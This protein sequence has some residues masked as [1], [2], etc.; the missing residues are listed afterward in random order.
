MRV[1]NFC[2]PDRANW[3]K[4]SIYGFCLFCDNP[5]S[6]LKLNFQADC[7]AAT[8]H[9]HDSGVLKSIIT[10][11]LPRY[12]AGDRR[13]VDMIRAL[14]S[15][16]KIVFLLTNSPYK[17]TDAVMSYLMGD[18]WRELFDVVIVE[19]NKPNWF[20]GNA[21]FKEIDI[22]TGCRKLGDHFGPLEKAAVYAGGNAA[23][24]RQQ[25][26]CVGK[27]VLYVGDHIIGD[28]LVSKQI[29][30]W[31]TL[32][33]VP[34]L[35]RELEIWHQHQDKLMEMRKN[36]IIEEDAYRDPVLA[37]KRLA[38]VTE[39]TEDMEATYGS[40]GSTLRCG[41]RHTHYGGKI[42]RYADLYTSCAYNLI[43]Y[44]GDHYFHSPMALM[45]H[46]ELTL[47]QK[48]T[49]GHEKRSG[50]AANSDPNSE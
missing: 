5:S 38:R 47:G 28:V 16:K 35:D 2:V 48:E 43:S 25:M 33:I 37:K 46:E 19:G 49:D 14:H 27:D 4:I 24:F 41:W 29:G 18:K 42:R 17:F 22:T 23:I 9:V 31:R 8:D 36:F 34:E 12:I 44:P 39:L 32:L 40:M 50:H 1:V 20:T 3:P 13:A 10:S 7:R 11:D 21:T 6:V 15:A 26:K 45:T 30:G